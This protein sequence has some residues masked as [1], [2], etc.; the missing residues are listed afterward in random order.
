M[1]PYQI[2]AIVATCALLLLGLIVLLV[3]KQR[4][5]STQEIVYAAV[6]I[7]LAF[8]LSYAR[9]W[10]LPQGGSVTLASMV[11][12]AIYSYKYGVVRGVLC[13]LIF[14]LLTSLLDPWIVHPVQYLLD[15]P[16]AFAFL[17]LSGVLKG[18]LKPNFAI[19]LGFLIGCAGRYL[20]H[21]VSGAI[22]F[23]TYG[24]DFGVGAW[25][26][27][28]LYNS[29]VWADAAIAIVCLF[30]LFSNKQFV[31]LATSDNLKG[32]FAAKPKTADP[33]TTPET[34]DPSSI[35]ET[36]PEATPDDSPAENE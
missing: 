7:A 10:R 24:A 2:V 25:A 5:S 34:T 11:P 28:F 18:K 3:S 1:S 15:Y 16:L 17:G 30:L 21:A 29:F 12:L 31:A 26:W 8:G 13:G 19:C 14:G 6:C 9:L 4:K 22:F 32:V 20:C 33:T 27:G 23:G 35:V 36:T